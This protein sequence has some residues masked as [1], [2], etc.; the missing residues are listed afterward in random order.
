MVAR[1]PQ[2]YPSIELGTFVVMPNHFHDILLLREIDTVADLRVCP[3]EDRYIGS[4][5][6]HA[7]SPLPSKPNVSWSQ[8]VQW[9]KTM[10]TNEYIR[11][12]RQWGWEQ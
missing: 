1:N 12:V 8:I 10:T 9:F 7:S 2:K 6:E 11:G 3:E 4:L 5:G